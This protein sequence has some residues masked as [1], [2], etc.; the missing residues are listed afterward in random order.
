MSRIRRGG[1]AEGFVANVNDK[2]SCTHHNTAF[3]PFAL[4]LTLF[5]DQPSSLAPLLFF[6][7]LFFCFFLVFVF[8]CGEGGGYSICLLFP[9]VITLYF[10]LKDACSAD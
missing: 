9:E 3:P 8:F 4:I 7:F 6:A 5:L 2:T 10:P 1:A